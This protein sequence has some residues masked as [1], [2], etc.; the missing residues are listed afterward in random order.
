MLCSEAQSPHLAKTAS[1]GRAFIVRSVF[2]H[3]PAP[4]PNKTNMIV[5]QKTT[6]QTKIIK[7]LG[8]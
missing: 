8:F 6:W 7:I 2:F 5:L 4:P 1:I 3:C